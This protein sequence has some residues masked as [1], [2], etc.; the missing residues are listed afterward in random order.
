[1]TCSLRVKRLY[2]N[3]I[4]AVPAISVERA[5]IYTKGVKVSAGE[6]ILIQRAR[7]FARVLEGMTINI[8][9][10]ELIV[11]NMT[12]KDRGAIVTPEFGWQWM[13][14]E[15]DLFSTRRA[16]PLQISEDEKESLKSL[17][18][19]WKGKSV[20]EKVN[21][22]ISAKMQDAMAAG[23][24]TLGGHATSIGNI[25]PD[26]EMVLNEGLAGM[27]LRV[28][29]QLKDL[30]FN[31]FEDGEKATFYEASYVALNAAIGFADRFSALARS[32]ADKEENP[33]RKEELQNISRICKHVPCH[34]P[35]TFHE[36]LQS[37]WLT[38]LMISIETNPHGLL[39]GR[40][41]QYLWPF[42][43]RDM[44]EGRISRESANELLCCFWIKITELIKI[45]DKF[46]SEAFS[47]FP[48]FQVAVIG[49]VDETGYDVTNDLSYLILDVIETVKTTQPS[50]SLRC[51]E[52]T[53]SELLIAACKVVKA[54]LG[55]PAFVN[56]N[57]IIPKMI[58]R[59]ASL[60]EARTYVT[61]CIE[62]D[63]PGMTD[64]RSHSG[65]INLGK[66]M[67]LV[68]HNG[69]DP[70]TGKQI[71]PQSG[72]VSDLKT[73][74][75][76]YQALMMQIRHAADLI[77]AA[78]NM[79][80]TVHARLVPEVFL[81]LFIHDCIQ[82]GK[83]RQSGG[84]RYNHST[85]FG[86][87]AATLVDSLLALEHLVF[88]EK[89]ITLQQ[90][91]SILDN[92]FQG[93][94]RFRQLLLN[95]C[96][97][98]GNDIEEADLLAHKLVS[99]FCDEI[100]K[101]KGMRN[102]T[103]IAEIHSV[104]MHTIFGK[105]CGATPNGRK[106]R[107]VVSDG[108]SPSQGADRKG[109]TATIKSVARLDHLKVLN[110]TL[111]NQKLSPQCLKTDADFEKMASLIKTYFAGGGHH[112]QFNIVDAKTLKEA[113]NNPDVHKSLIVRVAGYSAFFN[114]LTKEV[115]DEIIQRTEQRWE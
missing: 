42:Y 103:Y 8:N 33:G 69:M 31:S 82:K 111:F 113:Q 65:Y 11:G 64:S 38:H 10:D 35:R 54:G 20:E 36:A 4:D 115:Q 6:P 21:N 48:L 72:T 59:G 45:R 22:H 39:L 90:F 49:G 17:F 52:R 58:L 78:Y 101:R 24:T 70:F 75:D 9:K 107:Q 74:D 44:E 108:I 99:D 57:V 14:T 13:I 7:G 34:P 47:G 32:L 68:L 85:I 97:K 1:M 2:Q 100:Q 73:F 89:S 109:P 53:P 16:D 29:K 84:A 43:K 80:E 28:E 66:C 76:L 79:C 25:T 23:L 96:P 92:D 40:I 104:A 95:R 27:K 62:P 56:D 15:L 46:Y 86:T 81:S 50:I 63:I 51:H 41:D 19:F 94:E 37:L 93:E 26:Y 5:E 106:S 30:S 67:E 83:P 77:E 18:S 102:G 98:Y 91:I 71:G 88:N 87:G 114:E 3:L 55:I 12:E 61:N 110:G 112:I 105:L 60:E